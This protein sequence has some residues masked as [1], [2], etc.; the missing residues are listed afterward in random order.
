MDDSRGP[1]PFGNRVL[2]VSNVASS[3]VM[4][5]GV[6]LTAKIDLVLTALNHPTRR[7]MIEQLRDGHAS[8]GKLTKLSPTSVNTALKHIALLERAGVV[9]QAKS[10]GGQ[11]RLGL[12]LKPLDSVRE[13]MKATYSDEAQADTV[14][15]MPNA[16][17]R[18]RSLIDS[19][20]SD[21]SDAVR[22]AALDAVRQALHQGG[23]MK[24]NGRAS[25]N[26]S[27]RGTARREEGGGQED[28]RGAGAAD[29]R[30]PR[31]RDQ[32]PGPADRRDRTGMGASTKELTLPAKKLISA[33]SVKTKG[34]KRAT[35]YWAR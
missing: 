14:P 35:R 28:A 7:A 30:A 11:Y 10:P 20:V 9:W 6:L 32:E 15:P 33:K 23:G 5:H 17:D 3:A 27:V 24:P 4:A 1:G 2:P 19:F 25:S 31:V 26:G 16:D 22:E 18:I 8:R 29:G 13:W 12:D 34:V 21:L